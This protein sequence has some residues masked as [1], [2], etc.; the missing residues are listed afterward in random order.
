[1]KYLVS[2]MLVLVGIIHLL[3]LSGAVGSERLASLYGLQFNEPNLEILMRHRAV[4]FGLLG[5]FM[6][7]AAFKP[8]YQTVAFIGGFISVAS[9]L[10]LAWT[11]GGY[12]EQV[13]RVFVAD[14]VALGCLIVGGVVHAVLQ[15]E[16]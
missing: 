12:N 10:Y 13:G 6:V 7:F 14:V 16:V 3:P 15:R 8:A 1:M 5:T 11:V 4:L 2:A 9:F